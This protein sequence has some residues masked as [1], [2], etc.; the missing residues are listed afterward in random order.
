[1]VDI[2]NILKGIVIVIF[3]VL[4]IYGIPVA[5]AAKSYFKIKLGEEKWA[6]I[7]AFIAVAVRAAEQVF[8]GGNGA[9][10]KQW[11]YERIVSF[12][13][14]RGYDADMDAVD[15]IIESEVLNLPKK[16]E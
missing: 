4:T 16:G 5:V 10:K 3:G 9:D 11:A 12:L 1:M 14:D 2:T 7:R 6:S 15:S 13:N 8:G